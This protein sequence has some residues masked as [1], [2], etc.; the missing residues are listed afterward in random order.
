MD[1]QR[2][3]CLSSQMIL[4]VRQCFP[5]GIGLP[6]IEAVRFGETMRLVAGETA[7]ATEGK[8]AFQEKRAPVWQSK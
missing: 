4:G 8:Q 1:R 6:W 5:D 2:L 7:D 3:V